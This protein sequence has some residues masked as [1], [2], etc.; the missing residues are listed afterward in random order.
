MNQVELLLKW[1]R[2]F[3]TNKTMLKELAKYDNVNLGETNFLN[4]C[5]VIDQR[6]CAAWGA[7]L[8]KI[9]TLTVR[10]FVFTLVNQIV[11]LEAQDLIF[12][13]SDG[14]LRCQQL[15]RDLAHLALERGEFVSFENFAGFDKK[16]VTEAIR[17]V[18]AKVGIFIQTSIYD[19]ELIDV[20]FLNYLGENYETDFVEKIVQNSLANDYFS[21]PLRGQAD[22]YYV[23]NDKMIKLF[24]DKIEQL[25]TKR[26]NTKKTKIALSN[27][28]P[29][30]TQVLAKL[31]GHLDY[32]YVI[33]DNVR[34]KHMFAHKLLSDHEFLRLYRREIRF[35][36]QRRCNILLTGDTNGSRLLI[37]L[38]KRNN[39][40]FLNQNL[41][42]LV[43]LHNFFNNLFL[44]NKK[45][46]KSWIA[47]DTTPI[48]SITNL[49]TKYHIDFNVT[50]KLVHDPQNYLLFYWNDYNQFIFGEKRNVT[51]GIYNLFIKLLEILNFA[52]LQT[53]GLQNLVSNIN[54]MYGHFVQ[55]QV[56]SD[57]T[58][59][60]VQARINHLVVNPDIRDKYQIRAVERNQ[61]ESQNEEQLLWSLVLKKTDQLLVKYN[62]LLDKVIMIYRFEVTQ[63]KFFINFDNS[64][65]RQKEFRK[66]LKRIFS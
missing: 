41:T 58:L 24:V 4:P 31:L 43:F 59:Q 21:I 34:P 50:S 28:N 37:F 15:V 18:N 40:I 46:A 25:Y 61:S 19:P 20:F 62:Y 63:K 1:K 33:N 44:A 3:E 42:T 16:F 39:V 6:I 32:A 36:K 35:A 55:I 27:H 13:A 12:I 64:N 10:N 30:V 17:K 23:E 56:V 29:G 11:N 45:L 9:N 57:F 14:S 60:H 54:T 8:N 51:F 22:I 53:G 7:G 49:I 48:K 5:L 52:I 26:L 2:Y 65:R 47:A 38:L 66:L